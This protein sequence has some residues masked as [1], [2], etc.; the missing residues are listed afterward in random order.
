MIA[1]SIVLFLRQP[2]TTNFMPLSGN[3]LTGNIPSTLPSGLTYLELESNMFYGDLPAFPSTIK[4]M[5]LGWAG[6][7]GNHFTGTLQL[8]QPNEIRINDNWITDI[9]IQ[10]SSQLYICDLTNNPLVGNSNVALLSICTKTRLYNASSMPNT[11]IH[12]TTTWETTTSQ[13]TSTIISTVLSTTNEIPT[14]LANTHVP[15]SLS[16]LIKNTE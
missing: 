15:V 8:D 11:F 9:I 16:M 2:D 7:P 3:L 4:Q 1:G 10:D 14:T 12:S 6:R 5:F 13:I